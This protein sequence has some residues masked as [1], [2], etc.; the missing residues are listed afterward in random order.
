MHFMKTII[1]PIT[2]HA[3]KPLELKLAKQ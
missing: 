1:I 3:P 2:T